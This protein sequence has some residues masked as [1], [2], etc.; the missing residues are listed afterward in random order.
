MR[1]LTQSVVRTADSGQPLP[2]P[3]STVARAGVSFR[4]GQVSLLAGPPNGGKSLLAL[5]Y[6]LAAGVP[7]L[8]FS[9]DTDEWT[10]M[11]RAA[12]RL[13][14]DSTAQVEARLNSEGGGEQVRRLLRG[15]EHVQFCFDPS[16]TRDDIA[17]EVAAFTE[18]WGSA[19]QLVVVD[20]ILNV[21]AEHENE[22]S[23]LKDLMK[24]F[25]YIARMSKAHVMV[26]HHTSEGE[27]DPYSKPPARR[28][29]QGKI[30]QLPE[31]INT[32]VLRP[33]TGELLLACV[34]N[35]NGQHDATGGTFVTLYSAA[36]C[37]T[38]TDNPMHAQA[39]RSRA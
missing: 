8:Y 9:A 28:D 39:L 20:N 4:R 17:D 36:S 19:P 30:S 23:G 22:W 21:Q 18:A 35:R 16:P 15:A 3:W 27:K 12:A 32:V 31:V 38:V 11:V 25:H 13:S 5:N 24:D 7:T 26:L 2:M 6:A 14:G 10:T 29:I 37:M 1:S 34:K 33:T